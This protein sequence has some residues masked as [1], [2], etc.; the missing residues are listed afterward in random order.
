[1]SR[2]V[3]VVAAVAAVA[4]APLLAL[5]TVM[6]PAAGSTSAAP[7]ACFGYSTNVPAI[8]AT[9]RALESA[10]DYTARNPGSSASGAYQFTDATWQQIGA[11]AGIDTTS[12][13]SAAAAPP[14]LQDQVAAASVNDILE[15]SD[16]RVAAIPINWYLGHEPADDSPEWD[17]PPPGNAITPRDYVDRWMD[18][19]AGIV[20]D[21]GIPDDFCNAITG[22]PSGPVGDPI[23]PLVDDTGRTWSVPVAAT[24]FSPTQLDDPHHDY[25]AW[26]LMVPTGT[27]VYAL[28]DGTVARTTHFADNWWRA[29]CTTEG[30]NGCQ[31]CGTGVTVQT[32][33]GLRYTYCHTSGLY[34]AEGDHVAAGQQ[35]A[36]SG[37]T[38]R[39]GAPHLHVELRINDV[40]YCPQPIMQ[41]LYA[42]RTG[43]FTWTSQGCSF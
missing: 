7:V 27:P 25:P 23:N 22:A 10:G 1:M 28:T 35:V 40:R 8:L 41:A 24:A 13:P 4:V 33:I 43:P 15:R 30:Q 20:L 3:A 16:G 12:Y 18:T 31:T 34:V 19:Y 38:G 37:D 17:T 6:I 21:A 26:D 2:F 36:V 42:G 5:V 39:S 32:D 11:A 9:I 14:E 29:G